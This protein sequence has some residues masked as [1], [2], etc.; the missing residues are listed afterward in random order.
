MDEINNSN[1]CN[2]CENLILK[3]KKIFE[4][5]T[6]EVPYCKVFNEWITFDLR[7]KNCLLYEIVK[8]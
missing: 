1:F 6:K 4:D 2:G 7:C 3:E 5:Y 8:K